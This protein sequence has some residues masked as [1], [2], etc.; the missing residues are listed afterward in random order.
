MRE[1]HEMTANGRDV[2]DSGRQRRDRPVLEESG[3]PATA[4]P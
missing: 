1:V 2:T 3:E 4:G